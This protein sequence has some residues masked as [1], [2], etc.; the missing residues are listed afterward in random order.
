MLAYTEEGL[1]THLDRNSDVEL[2]LGQLIHPRS[3]QNFNSSCG[4][5]SKNKINPIGETHK[6]ER[7]EQSGM[8]MC[9][10][11]LLL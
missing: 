10:V 9:C 3:L 8:Y 11:K 7:T 4:I 1:Y 6:Y 2:G 5:K